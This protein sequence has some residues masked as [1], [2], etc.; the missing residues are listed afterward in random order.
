MEVEQLESIACQTY[1]DITVYIHDD[2]SS[3]KTVE[4]VEDFIRKNNSDIEFVL[5]D[6]ESGLKYPQCFIM[7]LIRLLGLK[8]YAF[9]DQDD[10]GIQIK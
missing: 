9:C 10:C 4:K 1:K 2:G 6:D 5:L 7:P 3:D 8:Y